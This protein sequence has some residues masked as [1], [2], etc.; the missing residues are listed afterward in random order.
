M[1]DKRVEELIGW[2]DVGTWPDSGPDGVSEATVWERPDGPQTMREA[3][4]ND[5]LLWIHQRH[6][7][8]CWPQICPLPFDQ[9]WEITLRGYINRGGSKRF[10]GFTPFDAA[11]AAVRYLVTR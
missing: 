3:D 9:G 7:R 4:L 6:H 11:E 2:I 10:E 1:T 8:D 5:L